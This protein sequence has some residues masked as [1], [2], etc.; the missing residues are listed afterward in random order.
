M[1]IIISLQRSLRFLSFKKAY[2]TRLHSERNKNV[3]NLHF[4][5]L[6]KYIYGNLGDTRWLY[7]H[8]PV[9]SASTILLYKVFR[10][11]S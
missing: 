2:H 9:K 4:K 11:I 1:T 3:S 7:N 5:C 10:R 8:K 6:L